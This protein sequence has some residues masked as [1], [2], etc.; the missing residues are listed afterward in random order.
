MN[1]SE[2]IFGLGYFD[3]YIINRKEILIGIRC[4]ILFKIFDRNISRE[5]GTKMLIFTPAYLLIFNRAETK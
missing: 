1:D 2:Y 3:L 4:R 5:I